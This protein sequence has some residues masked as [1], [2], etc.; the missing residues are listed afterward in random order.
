MKNEENIHTESINYLLRSKLGFFLRYGMFGIFLLG[1][2]VVL[3]LYFIKAPDSVN[4]N[5][6][7]SSTNPPKTLVAKTHGI[8]TQLFVGNRVE[9]SEKQLLVEIE[10]QAD[11]SQIQELD[12]LLKNTEKLI[13][14]K[15]FEDVEIIEKIVLKDLDEVQN[16]Y[17]VFKKANN[18]LA[19]MVSN[20]RYAKEKEI[21]LNR[22]QSL[23][24]MNESLMAQ[25]KIY[26]KEFVLAKADY[27]ADSILMKQRA[28]TEEMFRRSE[29]SLLSQ[30]IVLLNIEQKIINNINSKNDIYQQLLNLEK[31]LQQY[32]NN[33]IQSFYNLKTN[34]QE[35]KSRFYITSP[36]KGITSFNKNIYKGLHVQA[37]EPLIYLLPEGSDWVCEVLI[38]QANIGKLNV[39]DYCVLKFDSYNYEE[40]GTFDGTVISLS[41]LPQETK[42]PTGVEH[43]FLL[44][45][46]LSNGLVSSYNKTISGRYGLTGSV[47]IILEDKSLLEKLVLDKVYSI[48]KN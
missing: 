2:I 23:N 45:I 19:E 35:W 24:L 17:E 40:F 43:E 41:D 29:S 42:T 33:F 47:N 26:E 44:K 5:F 27:K 7:L 9:V 4:A 48:F 11:F 36:F 15:R 6:V 16:S 38:P 14:E 21:I 39:G 3:S 20:L 28:M 12:T 32:K 25:K 10:N 31:Q 13:S 18:E 37:G 34:L 8:I 1:F 30:Q 22:Q 46:K